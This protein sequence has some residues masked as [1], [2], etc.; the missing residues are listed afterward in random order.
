MSKI[1]YETM[2]TQPSPGSPST[3][4]SASLYDQFS[5]WLQREFVRLFKG[6][7]MVFVIIKSVLL[8]VALVVLIKRTSAFRKAGRAHPARSVLTY[9]V[10]LLSGVYV[11]TLALVALFELP[12]GAIPHYFKQPMTL[13][14][15][16]CTNFVCCLSSFVLLKNLDSP[17]FCSFLAL[18]NRQKREERPVDL[19][20]KEWKYCSPVHR[21]EG[22]R[23]Q[24][25][26]YDLPVIQAAD[27]TARLST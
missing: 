4:L 18:F 1:N 13:Y 23:H 22:D 17:E 27:D 25:L 3:A 19:E 5:E 2:A 7:K 20:S 11:I 9:I 6:F 15:L 21:K 16:S 14:L 24:A 8:S 12:W 26:E 10:Q